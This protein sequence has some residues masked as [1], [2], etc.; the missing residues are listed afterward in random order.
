VEEAQQRFCHKDY[1]GRDAA[2]Y[3]ITRF[4]C[5]ALFVLVRVNN[6]FAHLDLDKLNDG[7]G[8]AWDSHKVCEEDSRKDRLAIDLVHSLRFCG[9][10]C[11]FCAEFGSTEQFC[12]NTQCGRKDNTKASDG[13]YKAKGASGS[14]PKEPNGPAEFSNVQSEITPLKAPASRSY[15]SAGGFALGGL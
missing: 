7:F 4:A 10:R 1:V 11:T 12:S 9:Y 5:F 8:K 14:A 15:L 3:V 6:A 13:L 2:K